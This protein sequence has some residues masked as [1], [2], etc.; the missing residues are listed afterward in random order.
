[1]NQLLIIE[2]QFLAGI[3][4]QL[5]LV[6]ICFYSI[7]FLLF[8]VEIDF[9]ISVFCIFLITLSSFPL[10]Y[11]KDYVSFTFFSFFI[12]FE[13]FE[14][15]FEQMSRFFVVFL[16]EEVKTR[17]KHHLTLII[18]ELKEMAMQDIPH[19]PP[20]KFDPDKDDFRCFIF[21]VREYCNLYKLHIGMNRRHILVQGLPDSAIKY[22][23]EHYNS[24]TCF[25]QEL[26]N[27]ATFGE[28]VNLLEKFYYKDDTVK[29]T[30]EM[31]KDLEETKLNESS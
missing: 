31:I 25:D 16:L 22:I 8:F 17:N 21:R 18:L 10:K 20:P 23:L 7:D 13:D 1:M 19:F 24:R 14:N 3:F 6:D 5:F 27:W 9:Y 15:I 12:T 26:T 28:I 4:S 29:N 2:E 30:E 11:D